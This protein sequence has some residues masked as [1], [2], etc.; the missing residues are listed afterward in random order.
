[1]LHSLLEALRKE[2]LTN[3]DIR[4]WWNLS[5]IERVLIELTD[6]YQRTNAYVELRKQL[7]PEEAATILCQRQVIYDTAAPCDG[8][9]HRPLPFAL[10]TRIDA[11]L[12][13]HDPEL[14]VMK[15]AMVK[16]LNAVI[17]EEIRQGRL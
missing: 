8:P 7:P 5:P 12:T 17:R 2:G 14:L 10:K 13:S 9:N 11:Y 15:T 3:D 6:E 1:M 4:A 16:S